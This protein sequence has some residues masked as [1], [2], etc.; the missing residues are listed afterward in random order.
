MAPGLIRPTFDELNTYSQSGTLRMLRRD[1]WKLVVDMQG[2]GQLY[3]LADDP[4][5]TRNLYN[6]ARY[7]QV[8]CKLVADLLAWTI[9]MTDPL[10]YPKNKYVMKVD[11][12]NWWAPYRGFASLADRE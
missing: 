4:R 5:E 1:N 6:D 11:P 2:A 7:A 8:Q 10:P 12:H 9:R 3:D